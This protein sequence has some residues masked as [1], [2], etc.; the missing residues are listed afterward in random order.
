VAGGRGLESPEANAIAGGA[1][2]RA[3]ERASS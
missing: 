1:G 3:T 2:E